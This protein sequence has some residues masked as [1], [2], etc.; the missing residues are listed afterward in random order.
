MV[1]TREICTWANAQ[2]L[3]LDIPFEPG[4]ERSQ[5]EFGNG[6]LIGL[7]TKVP[8]GA[9]ETHDGAFEEFAI[10]VQLRARDYEYDDLEKDAG[11]LDAAL[12]DIENKSIWGTYIRYVLRTGTVTPSFEEDERVSFLA[13]YLIAEGQ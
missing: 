11:T 13:N 4:P 5:T 8:G 6:D 12:R 9:G 7:V 1:A 10:L 3:T 2:P